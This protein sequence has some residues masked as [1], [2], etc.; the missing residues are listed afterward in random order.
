LTSTASSWASNGQASI[1]AEDFLLE[2]ELS[3]ESKRLVMLNNT[4]YMSLFSLEY[5]QEANQ[6]NKRQVMRLKKQ[7][8]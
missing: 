6:H 3:D 5:L 1:T 8:N 2:R 4:G 7:A